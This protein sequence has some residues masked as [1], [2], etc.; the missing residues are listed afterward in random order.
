M[1]YL[2][3][4]WMCI[5]VITIGLFIKIQ[6]PKPVEQVRLISFDQYINSI[7]KTKSDQIVL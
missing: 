5:A 1:K 6:D 2:T 3:S 4:I 7:P